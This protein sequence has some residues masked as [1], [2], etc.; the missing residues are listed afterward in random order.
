MRVKKLAMSRNAASSHDSPKRLDDL[1]KLK[2]AGKQ[3]FLDHMLKK[4]TV[5]VGDHHL[6]LPSAKTLFF[7]KFKGKVEGT[8]FYF[9]KE[10]LYGDKK[11]QKHTLRD[12]ILVANQRLGRDYNRLQAVGISFKENFFTLKDVL[13]DFSPEHIVQ[14]PIPTLEDFIRLSNTGV[15]IV[16]EANLH[17]RLKIESVKKEDLWGF[18]YIGVFWIAYASEEAKV[19][20]I[21]SQG[22]DDGPNEEKRRKLLLAN[23]RLMSDLERLKE[24]GI[25]VKVIQSKHVR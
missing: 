1:I 20:K 23:R 8:A 14:T 15:D 19:E 25:T 24:A 22:L 13:T 3:I 12:C 10:Y 9:E 2:K 7:V 5:S 18:C 16:V 11:S 21:Y 6:G 17:R 4:K